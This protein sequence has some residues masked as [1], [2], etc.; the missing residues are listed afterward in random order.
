MK[1]TRRM[2]DPTGSKGGGRCPD[3]WETDEDSVVVIGE[4]V[5]DNLLGNL[6]ANAYINQGER[7]VAIPRKVFLSARERVA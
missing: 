1:L 7:A 6:P 2:N 4:D 3:I 5:T